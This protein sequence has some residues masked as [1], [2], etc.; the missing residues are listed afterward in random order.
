MLNVEFFSQQNIAFIF[1]YF[2]II[3]IIIY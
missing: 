3:I 1:I 2:F